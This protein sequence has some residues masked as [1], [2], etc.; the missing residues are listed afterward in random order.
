MPKQ[1]IAPKGFY[2]AAA[3]MKKL[4]MA[5]S[6][7]YDLVEKGTIKKVVQP[8]RSEGYY[9]KAT[10]DDLV[11]ARELFTLQYA[12]DAASF[13][14]ATEQDIR[15]IY[16]LTVSLW[17]ALGSVPYETRLA[18]YK[19]NSDIYYVLKYLDIVVGF[20]AMMPLSERAVEE[21]LETGKSGREIFT[22]DDILPFVPGKL[23]DYLFLE[24][25]VRDGVP[26]PKQ[27]AMHLLLGASRALEDYARK[28]IFIKKL[29]GTSNKIDG[30]ELARKFGFKEI[31]L[32]PNGEKLAFELDVLQSNSPLLREYQKI[33]NATKETYIAEEEHLELN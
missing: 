19:R 23:I 31:L 21:T 22:S 30:V 28:G 6:S 24:I 29:F 20:I 26:K 12:T 2:T 1:S 18:R 4:G 7:F 9:L 11:K 5:R 15:G 32:P 17:G 8:G 33:I 10:I 25:A 13:E 3:A 14:K 16:D 27:Y